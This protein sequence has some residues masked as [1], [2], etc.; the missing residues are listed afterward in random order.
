MVS[1]LDRVPGEYRYEPDALWTV[2]KGGL[3]DSYELGGI[4]RSWRGA[5]KRS[6]T[7]GIAPVLDG[8]M[9][10]VESKQRGQG[11]RKVW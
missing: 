9:I 2:P 3:G 8:S 5:T 7:G 11:F 10:V 4:P 1:R 6:E